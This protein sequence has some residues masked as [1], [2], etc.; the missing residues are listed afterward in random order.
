M[1]EPQKN[2]ELVA[3]RLGLAKD[4]QAMQLYQSEFIDKKLRHTIYDENDLALDPACPPLA[5]EL[6]VALLDAVTDNRQQQIEL[7]EF[8]ARTE[9]WINEFERLKSSL[10]LADQLTAQV[11]QLNQSIAVRN[12]EITGIVT[13][14]IAQD[15]NIF[16]QEFDPAWYVKKYPDIDPSLVD[17]YQHYISYG[18]SEGRIPSD[19][20]IGFTRD[21]L[22]NALKE[23]Q[24]QRDQSMALA[25]GQLQ[26]IAEQKKENSKQTDILNQELQRLQMEYAAREHTHRTTIDSLQSELTNHLRNQAQK[27]QE[28]SA[29]ILGIQRQADTDKAALSQQYEAVI[30]ELHDQK[31]ENEWLTAERIN[32]LNQELQRLQTEYA[33]REHTHRTTID[34]LQSELTNNLRNQSQREQEISAQILGIQRQA[35]TDKAALSQQYEAVIRELHDQKAENEWLTAERINILNQELQRLQTE[36]AARELTHRTTMDSLQSELTN[37]LRNQVQREQ[38]ISAQILGIQRQAD[39]DKAALSQQYEAKI[40]TLHDQK[41]EHEQISVERIQM[42]NQELHHLRSENETGKRVHAEAIVSLQNKLAD[43]LGVQVQREREMASQLIALQQQAEQEKV[44]QAHGYG[45]QERVLHYRY[46]EREKKL[47]QQIQTD[48]QSHEQQKSEQ[49]REYVEAF[50]KQLSIKQDEIHKLTRNWL[51]TEQA[52]IQMISHLQHQLNSMRNTFLWRSTAPFRNLIRLL[53][54][55]NS[56][57][58]DAVLKSTEQ[59]IEKIHQNGI[60]ETQAETVDDTALN[61]AST[62]Q[63]KTGVRD[64][65]LSQYNT[66][67][68]TLDELLS[69]HD[70]RFIRCAYLTLLGRTPDA[71][72]MGFYLKKIRSGTS[73]AEIIYQISSSKEGKKHHAYLAGLDKFILSRRWMRYS[74][75]RMLL[76]KWLDG[77]YTGKKIRVLENQLYQLDE[78]NK[79]YHV[80]FDMAISNLRKLIVQQVQ[81]IITTNNNFQKS[82]AETSSMAEKHF[83]SEWYLQRYPDVALSGMNPYE[84]YKKYGK[85]E[86]REMRYFSLH[87]KLYVNE[88][89]SESVSNPYEYY[90]NLCLDEERDAEKLSPIKA[91]YFDNEAINY[92]GYIRAVSGLGSA[93]RSYIHA[94]QHCDRK[95]TALNLPCGLEEIDFPVETTPNESAMFNI[96]HMNADSIQYFF[97][98]MGKDCLAGRYNIGLWVWELAAFRPDWYDSFMPFHEIW[99]PSEF[100]KQSISAISPVPVYVVPHV[101]EEQIITDSNK[102]SYFNLPDEVFIFGYMFDCSSSIARK[103]PF[104]LI[105]AFK[106]AYAK[107]ED[108]ILLLK[109]ANGDMDPELYHTIQKVIDGHHNIRTIERSLDKI[110]VIRF[111]DVIDCYV[112][113]HRTEGFGLTIAEA[114]LAGKPV[115]ATDYGGSTDFVKSGHAYPVR[116]DLVPIS[117]Q[118]GPYLPGYIWAE[119]DIDHLVEQLKDVYEHQEIA[120]LRGKIACNFVKEQYSVD[121]IA[122]IMTNRFKMILQ[123]TQG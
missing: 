120:L 34:S 112:S 80:Q 30:R 47:I 18:I 63:N 94:L 39:T 2:L 19:N 73:K 104:S 116:C 53:S 89:V 86:G 78:K 51:A 122:D 97:S 93:S 92:Y 85:E 54:V 23:I 7:P 77:G 58:D 9:I 10:R 118:H 98:R 83:D 12:A 52:Q 84:H 29:Q 45:E 11:N 70:E 105:K 60:I 56:V 31:A 14:A 109:I 121:R 37:H 88:G 15:P 64:M 102:R 67:V 66:A 103:N 107:S 75:L 96:V 33:E 65:S 72:G 40:Q 49:R 71:D 113:P 16:K 111:F 55:N 57:K 17:P 22:L 32:I 5:H 27:E 62:L 44:K 108:V 24:A 123:K 46:A 21:G 35:D 91:E 99:V 114:M 6:Y 3:K 20:L 38:E 13:S 100:C 48:Q 41:A 106:E 87:N 50:N 115:I 1:E 68:S 25:E 81:S 61:L 90:A 26:Q 101:V 36:Y 59:V 79:K 43:N 110:D 8:Y 82:T 4:A 42:L 76:C 69:Y 74:F 117:Q 28:I 95:V 119:P